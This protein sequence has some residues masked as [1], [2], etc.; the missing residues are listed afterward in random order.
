MR[1]INN[2]YIN[3]RAFAP[4]NQF[5]FYKHTIL[6]VF[7]LPML[8]AENLYVFGSFDFNQNGKSEIFKLK[9]PSSKLEFVEIENDGKHNIVWTYIPDNENKV[10]LDAKFSDINN[11]NIPEVVIIESNTIDNSWI[12]IFEWNGYD[13][14]SNN[15][16]ITNR[17]KTVDKIRPSNLA[18]LNEFFAVSKSSP[19]RSV[20]KFSINVNDGIREVVNSNTHI[21]PIVTNGYGPVFT[22]LFSVAD[23]DYGVLMSPEGNIIKMV[24]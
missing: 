15:S 4:K 5:V 18:V 6:A 8:Y 9:T 2:I 22:G 12:K 17:D 7:L 23:Q 14:S 24:L 10:I 3:F 11:D 19:T 13:F 16:P 1:I 21:N 20:T